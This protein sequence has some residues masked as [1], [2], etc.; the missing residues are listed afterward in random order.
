LITAAAVIAA[1]QVTKTIAQD[2]LADGPVDLI[3]GVVTFRLTYN[4]GAAFG[5][6]RGR[7]GLFLFVTLLVV[8]GILF[9]A[10][11]LSRPALLVPLGMVAGGGLSNV[12]DRVF[13]SGD[14]RVIDFVDLH[15]WPIFNVADAS[16]VVGV[17]LVVLA[18]WVHVKGE[19]QEAGKGA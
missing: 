16:I 7:P 2:R 6:G 13:R 4:T 5:L 15:W 8:L 14:G 11:R 12:A 19:D 1:D 18:S 17:M 10:R 3:H 9:Y